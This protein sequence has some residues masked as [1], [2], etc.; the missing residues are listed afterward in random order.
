MPSNLIHLPVCLAIA[1]LAQP[2][3]AQTMTA[4]TDSHTRLHNAPPATTIYE[5]D[6]GL[7]IEDAM[8]VDLPPNPQEAEQVLRARM[9]SAEWRAMEAQLTRSAEG[10]AKAKALGVTTIPAVV[11]DDRYVVYGVTDVAQAVQMIQAQEASHEP[12]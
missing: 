9:Q 11:V 2:A 4:F 10:L 6:A 7:R 8:S 5:L 3:M 12:D 1:C